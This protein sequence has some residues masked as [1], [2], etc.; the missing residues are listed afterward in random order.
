MP[1]YSACVRGLGRGSALEVTETHVQGGGPKSGGQVLMNRVPG[2]SQFLILNARRLLVSHTTQHKRLLLIH[3]NQDRVLAPGTFFHPAIL[4]GATTAAMLTSRSPQRCSA[5][6]RFPS[7]RSRRSR[8]QKPSRCSTDVSDS[9]QRLV[10]LSLPWS[11]GRAATHPW[12][13]GQLLISNSVL[14]KLLHPAR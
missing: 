2:A 12:L 13:E 10:A 4:Q 11:R 7:W 3:H 5:R 6:P 9:G 1:S 8:A 14:P